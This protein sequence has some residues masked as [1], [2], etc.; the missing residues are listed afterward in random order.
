MQAVDK[1]WYEQQYSNPHSD[2]SKCYRSIPDWAHGKNV[3]HAASSVYLCGLDPRGLKVLDLGSGLGHF[4]NAFEQIGAIVQ[5]VEISETAARN[6]PNIDCGDVTDLRKYEG[7]YDIVF[8]SQLFEHLTDEE[9]KKTFIGS[10]KAAPAQAHFI[11]DAVGNDPTHI[12]IKTPQEWAEFL[13]PIAADF[14][15]T[16]IVWHGPLV[17]RNPVFL[18]L[19]NVPT[20][21]AQSHYCNLN[22]LA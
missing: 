9:V 22:N 3:Y 18:T 20:F 2:Y 5:G 6:K 21:L 16:F 11:A 17:H 8:S 12:N 15:R 13:A 10:I 1:G 14:G 4:V 7:Q 19:E